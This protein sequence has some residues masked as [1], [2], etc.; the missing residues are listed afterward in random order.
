MLNP[1]E[2]R[3]DIFNDALLFHFGGAQPEL[4]LFQEVESIGFAGL[5]TLA[6]LSMFRA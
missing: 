2:T 5:I 4:Q 1:N 3:G 6:S